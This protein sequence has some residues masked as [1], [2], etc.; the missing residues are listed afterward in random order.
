M[1]HILLL[2]LKTMNPRNITL[3][4]ALFAP[5]VLFV[6]GA[7]A[8]G[9][10]PAPAPNPPRLRGFTI[11]NS[12]NEAASEARFLAIPSAKECKQFLRVLTEDPHP[13]GSENGKALAEYV[14]ARFLQFGFEAELVAYDVLLS[15]PKNAPKSIELQLL[16]PEKYDAKLQE[17]GTAWDKDSFTSAALGNFHGYSPGGEVTADVVYV[18][19]GLPE[20]YEKLDQL[21]IDVRGKVVITRYG[22]CYRGVKV[23]EAELR[24]AAAVII[25]SDP[26]D[27]GYAKGDVVPRGPW[28]PETSIQRGSVGYM[29]IQPGDP[30]TPGW[31]SHKNQRKI[32]QEAVTGASTPGGVLPGIP[33][34]PLSYADATPILK[35]LSGANVPEGWQGSLPFAYHVGPGPSR[36]RL[37]VDIQWE[38]KTI[39]N[40][41]AKWKGNERPDEWVVMGNHRDAW[42][43]GAVDPNSGTASILECARALGKLKDAG[44]KPKRTIVFGSWDAEEYG[45]VGSTEWVEELAEELQKKAVAYINVDSGVSGRNFSAGGAPSL[46]R[47]IRDVAA[48]VEDPSDRRSILDVWRDRTKAK[49]GPGDNANN[50][51]VNNDGEEPRVG[52]LGSGSDYTAFQH[53]LGIPS[54]DVQFSGPYGV[55]HSVL[56]NFYWMEKFGDPDFSAHRALARYTGVALLRLSNSDILPI[57]PEAQATAF[58]L[59][60]SELL[61][62]FPEL[63]P[64]A[65]EKLKAFDDVKAAAARLA[66]V[67]KT[68]ES[69][70]ER[71]LESADDKAID[72]VNSRLLKFERELIHKEGLRGRPFFKHLYSAP[73]VH[74][75]YAASILPGLREAMTETPGDDRRILAECQRLTECLTN[76]A[77]TLEGKQKPIK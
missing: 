38:N 53:H 70:A 18:N 3:C 73:G 37:K 25:Y 41:I 69:E 57:R 76:A 45:L 28:R 11:K 60:V 42:V 26:A 4:V 27:D 22:K 43:H 68:L 54:I 36:V 21:G 6:H 12:Q 50:T 23:R 7:F 5:V 51:N 30:L 64:A 34:I 56:D 49:K 72:T 39:Y 20:D 24:K 46:A 62:Q 8:Q 17:Q 55:Y 71:A 52:D 40:V 44:F 74:T 58:T 10:T 32:E 19:Y 1:F 14:R 61:K 77:D 48:D 47:F 65:S 16:E 63:V 31:A 75:G 67:A 15:T 59:A 35:N 13:A 33:S 9:D 29:F 2:S 66:Q